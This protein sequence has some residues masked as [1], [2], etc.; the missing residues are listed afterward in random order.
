MHS[1]QR[2]GVTEGLSQLTLDIVLGRE[3]ELLEKLRC[4]GN[5]SSSP[6]LVECQ[7]LVYA[8]V[9]MLMA[10]ITIA[11][12]PLIDVQGSRT[13]DLPFGPCLVEKSFS[14]SP[15][16]LL[17]LYAL[18]SARAVDPAESVSSSRA[19]VGPK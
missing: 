17:I 1:L 8:A 6:D 18:D 16:V 4:N 14:R 7:I 19:D 9:Y 15:L 3:I 12:K 11:W 13:S 2:S 5:A 10:T